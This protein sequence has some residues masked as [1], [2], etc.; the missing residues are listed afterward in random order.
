MSMSCPQ[1][2]DAAGLEGLGC[3]CYAEAKDV[4]ESVYRPRLA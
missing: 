4:V 2:R 1:R 3:G